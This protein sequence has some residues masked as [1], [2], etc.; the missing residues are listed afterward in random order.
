VLGPDVPQGKGKPRG[1]QQRR[2]LLFGRRQGFSSIR[3][4]RRI[5]N[6]LAAP[7]LANIP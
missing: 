3:A 6:P 7:T 4:A 1:R 2:G 5:A